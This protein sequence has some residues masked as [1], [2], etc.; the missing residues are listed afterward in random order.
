M[1]AAWNALVQWSWLRAKQS[2]VAARATT[3]VA[4]ARET[5]SRI[6]TSSLSGTS[7]RQS[8]VATARAMSSDAPLRDICSYI[9]ANSLWILIGDPCPLNLV[10]S[11]SPCP[12]W[13]CVACHIRRTSGA[14]AQLYY[15]VECRLLPSGMT[16]SG[17]PLCRA[18][19][20]LRARVTLLR[21]R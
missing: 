10:A 19:P 16:T 18:G 20:Q 6:A 11:A 2:R 13:R 21:Q 1:L 5:P 17:S 9:L 7:S 14:L 3:V 12:W 15:H 4:I 8:A